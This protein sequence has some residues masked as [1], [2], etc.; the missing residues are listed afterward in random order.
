MGDN[1]IKPCLQ[2]KRFPPLA[3]LEPEATRSARIMLQED[4]GEIISFYD[5]TSSC[6]GL[7]DKL[8]CIEYI[9]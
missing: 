1:E 3:G 8:K 5:Q 4:W 9:R 7:N 6:F 2:L